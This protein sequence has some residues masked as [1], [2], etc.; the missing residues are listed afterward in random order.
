MAKWTLFLDDERFLVDPEEVVCRTI[1]DAVL[2][3]AHR[4]APTVIRFD[5][6]LGGNETGFEFIKILIDLDQ[7]EVHD[8][9]FP[10][11]FS[12]TIHSQNPIGAENIR[13]L[14]TQYLEWRDHV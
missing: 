12:F 10:D 11:D 2:E 3:I 1:R 13:S 7:S 14:L 4:G 6:D 9:R 5:H 8:F